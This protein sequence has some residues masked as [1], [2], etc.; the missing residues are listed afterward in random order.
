MDRTKKYIEDNPEAVYALWAPV[1]WTGRFPGSR[2]DKTTLYIVKN[3]SVGPAMLEIPGYQTSHQED[4]DDPCKI[5]PGEPVIV[6]SV[7][8]TV[9]VLEGP[10]KGHVL[11][12]NGLEPGAKSRSAVTLRKLRIGEAPDEFSY[13]RGK[14]NYLRNYLSLLDSMTDV[15]PVRPLPIPEFYLNTKSADTELRSGNEPAEWL[16]SL[17][18]DDTEDLPDNALLSKIVLD[19][20]QESD[21]G[22]AVLPY[23]M[24]Y[25]RGVI[26]VIGH[27]VF[28]LLTWHRVDS[29]EASPCVMF[30]IPPLE[31][32]DE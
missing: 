32:I 15:L 28:P 24:V 19:R 14:D 9:R 26:S 2:L 13:R 23:R 21:E 10:R 18:T 22:A 17:R 7:R 6:Y 3:T 30:D 27:E 20:I 16:R 1:V 29:I 25:G 8:N 11:H 12:R 31:Q 4:F 5:I